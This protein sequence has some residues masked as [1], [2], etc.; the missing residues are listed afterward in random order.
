MTFKGP[1]QPKPLYAQAINGK[2]REH[3]FYCSEA[4]AASG[5]VPVPASYTVLSPAC[6]TVPDAAVCESLTL[7]SKEEDQGKTCC[8]SVRRLAEILL[9]I[10]REALIKALAKMCCNRL[11]CNCSPSGTL[12][13]IFM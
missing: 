10:D 6:G 3:L 1:F 5:L 8:A 11:Y 12:T 7:L 2:S 9:N 13:L 4:A